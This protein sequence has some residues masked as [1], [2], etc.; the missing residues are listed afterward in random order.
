MPSACCLLNLYQNNPKN[1]DR[2]RNTEY[3][4]MIATDQDTT[5]QCMVKLGEMTASITSYVAFVH[6]R[7]FENDSG[8]IQGQKILHNMASIM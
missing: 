4:S 2:K 7:Y 6:A 5:F 1:Q 8:V 3:K